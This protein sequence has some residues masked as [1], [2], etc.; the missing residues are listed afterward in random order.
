MHFEP[1]LLFGHFVRRYQRFLMEAEL[2]DGRVVTAHCTNTGSLRTCHGA[3]WPVGLSL[4][5]N[6]ERR[7]PYTWELSHNGA[8][9]IGVNTLRANRLAEEAV[10]AG[11]LPELRGYGQ[12][13][14]EQA[15]GRHSRVDLLLR[16]AQASDSCPEPLPALPDCYVEVKN[17]TLLGTD[18]S[19]AFPDAVTERGLKHLRDLEGVVRRGSRGVMLFVVQR[20][21]GTFFRPAWE[22]DPEYARALRRA[23]RRGVEVLAYRAAI[24]PAA[25]ALRERLPV[26][27]GQATPASARGSAYRTGGASRTTPE[28]AR[29][30]QGIPEPDRPRGLADVPRGLAQQVSCPRHPQTAEVLHGAGPDIPLEDAAELGDRQRTGSG[31]AR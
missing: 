1:P 3:D 5:A 23:V 14:R 24:T 10:R 17:V 9:W 11:W 18:G 22:I 16:T 6:P 4:A 27:L 15:Y 30:V 21:D 8:C 29:E 19:S 31:D 2:A 26:D 7:L 12:V 20:G 25:I 28:H 13:L